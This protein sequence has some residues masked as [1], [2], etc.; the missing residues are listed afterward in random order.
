MFFLKKFLF[1][2][3]L[4]LKI[5]I[6]TL[7]LTLLID[8]IFGNKILDLIDPY[9]KKTEFYDKRIRV[10]DKVFHHTFKKNVN[11]EFK[12]NKKNSTLGLNFQYTHKSLKKMIILPILV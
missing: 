7:V 10:W 8:Y 3:Y 6:F 2:L 11:L 5:I 12:T 1:Y 9:L 4:T